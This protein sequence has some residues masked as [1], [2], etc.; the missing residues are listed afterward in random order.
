MYETWT[1]VKDTDI[2]RRQVHNECQPN[3][4]MNETGIKGNQGNVGKRCFVYQQTRTLKNGKRSKQYLRSAPI[5]SC[6]ALNP[7]L[8]QNTHVLAGSKFL[9]VGLSL[10]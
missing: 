1:Q 9:I 2:G 8:R 6:L 10:N 4:R 7:S 5:Q 3:P